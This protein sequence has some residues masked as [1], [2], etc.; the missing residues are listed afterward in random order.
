MV[1]VEQGEPIKEDRFI[2]AFKKFGRHCHSFSLK[3]PPNKLVVVFEHYEQAIAAMSMDT[4]SFDGSVI[5][6]KLF[7]VD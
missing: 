7:H 3:K 6:L 1:W 5:G 2:V 4:H